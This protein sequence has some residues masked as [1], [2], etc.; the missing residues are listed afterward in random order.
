MATSAHLPG[1]ELSRAAN[2]VCSHFFGTPPTTGSRTGRE[3]ASSGFAVVA[4]SWGLN[5]MAASTAAVCGGSH[6]LS[7]GY[8][9]H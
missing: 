6:Q 1:S 2:R 9:A 8:C 3:A 5:F 4:L 7:F